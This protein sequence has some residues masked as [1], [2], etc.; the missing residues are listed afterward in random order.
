M[1]NPEDDKEK[2]RRPKT[3]TLERPMPGQ[4]EQVPPGDDGDINEGQEPHERA[5]MDEES[6]IKKKQEPIE[7]E[8]RSDEDSGCAC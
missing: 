3:R 5:K 4:N 6:R 1:T 7:T 2:G 8:S